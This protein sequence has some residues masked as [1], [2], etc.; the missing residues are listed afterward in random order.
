M[1]DSTFQIEQ[2]I[3]AGT[4]DPEMAHG[5]GTGIMNPLISLQP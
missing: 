1:H 2:N 4:P 5:F 3:T